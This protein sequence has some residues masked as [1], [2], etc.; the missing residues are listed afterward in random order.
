MLDRDSASQTSTAAGRGVTDNDD[1]VSRLGV[2]TGWGPGL[3]RVSICGY[4]A[5]QLQLFLVKCYWQ[6]TAGRLT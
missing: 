6:P 1:D 3:A 4:F 5:S 2:V